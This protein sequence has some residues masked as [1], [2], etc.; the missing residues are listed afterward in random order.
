[1][2][3]LGFRAA[4][5]HFVR[6]ARACVAAMRAD[7]P[8][9]EA[10]VDCE[11]CTACCYMDNLQL[12]QEEGDSG[13]YAMDSEGRLLKRADG[14]CVYLDE[15]GRGCSIYHRR[16]EI[17]R[18]FD[19]RIAMLI[20]AK[21]MP[22]VLAAARKRVAPPETMSDLVAVLAVT[23]VHI[24]AMSITR[25][26]DAQTVLFALLKAPTRLK[27]SRAMVTMLGENDVR[28]LLRKSKEIRGYP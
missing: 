17:C 25:K 12:S 16:P 27:A 18:G 10:T 22:G 26:N 14:G 13:R 24:K 21:G 9:P 20:P 15:S 11:G 8:V 6:H 1:M 7:K 3:Q 4:L 23:A 28:L 2:K 19:C 5:S